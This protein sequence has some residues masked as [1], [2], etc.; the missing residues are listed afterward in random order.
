MGFV[1]GAWSGP[2]IGSTS[3]GYVRDLL[4]TPDGS[5][6]AAADNDGLYRW[7]GST[8]R[9]VS[10][11][12][13]VS[14][15]LGRDGVVRAAMDSELGVVVRSYYLDGRTWRQGASTAP[16]TNLIASPALSSPA[17][18]A[19][20]RDGT[21]WVGTFGWG[22]RPHLLRYVNGAWELV[23]PAGGTAP[24]A[25]SDITVAPNGDVWVVGQTDNTTSFGPRWISRFD[26]TRWTLPGETTWLSPDTWITGIAAAADGTIW[27]LAQG[28]LAR[29]DGT[30]WTRL[31]E[32]LSLAAISVAPDGTVWVHGP[33][34]VVRL[35]AP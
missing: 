8:W 26:G 20:G 30:R 3:S 7:N 17:H 34:G 22:A 27:A 4:R 1:N 21:I 32:T 28:G 29:F 33:S 9:Q 6:W 35:P 24:V 13:T 14:L 15:A 18:L 11:A 23:Y 5:V 10:K 25:V 19:V 31:Y 16:P 12:D 2:F